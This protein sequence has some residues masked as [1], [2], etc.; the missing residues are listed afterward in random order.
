MMVM[1]LVLLLLKQLNSER[2][3]Y[4]AL[5]ASQDTNTRTARNHHTHRERVVSELEVHEIAVV[6]EQH[7][8][9]TLDNDNDDE[10]AQRT[11]SDRRSCGRIAAWR[12]GG[13]GSI[14]AEAAGSGGVVGA[15]ST[16]MPSPG[17][18][19]ASCD[20]SS[21]T[22]ADKAWMRDLAWM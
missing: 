10:E 19:R 3:G 12:V 21:D 5:P 22:C 17:R 14:C 8:Q 13:R 6:G 1:V 15:A 7:E 4:R 9:P 16:G 2:R 18:V 20:L 11:S